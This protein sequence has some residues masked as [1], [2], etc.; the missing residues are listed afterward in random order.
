LIQAR[1]DALE[2]MPVSDDQS[3]RE[4]FTH[5]MV[6]V[7]RVNE[8]STKARAQALMGGGAGD[9][10]QEKLRDWLDRLVGALP[11]IVG[12]LAGATAFSVSVAADVTVTVDF[13]LSAGSPAEG[14]AGA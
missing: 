2:G 14:P 3:A 11:R 13:G 7:S 5:L 4:A 10:I 8:L 1:L 12:N 9:E 6:T